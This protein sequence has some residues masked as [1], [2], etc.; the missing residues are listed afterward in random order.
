MKNQLFFIA[1]TLLMLSCSKVEEPT[2]LFPY[3]DK[4]I[5]EWVQVQKFVLVDEHVTPPKYDWQEIKDG[6]TLSLFE[7]GTFNYTKFEECTTG[8]YAFK[9]I[10]PEIELTFDCE[11]EFYG[12]KTSTYS[13]IIMENLTQNNRLQ[14]E[15]NYG[16]SLNGCASECFSVFER[17][18]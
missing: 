5:G 4:I 8:K 14:L 1:F 18:K 3:Q 7:D 6:Y 2:M 15:H 12:I 10:F 13:E 17:V 9:G 16:K 11:I